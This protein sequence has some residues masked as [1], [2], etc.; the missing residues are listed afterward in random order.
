MWLTHQDGKCIHSK[1]GFSS[2]ECMPRIVPESKLETRSSVK[3]LQV[4]GGLWVACQAHKASGYPPYLML[5][6]GEPCGNVVNQVP[7]S[8]LLHR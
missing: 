2:Q 8:C 5:S 6:V 4:K 7:L 3:G 1:L